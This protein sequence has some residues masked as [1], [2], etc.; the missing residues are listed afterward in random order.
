[1]VIRSVICGQHVKINVDI[2]KKKNWV[3][4]EETCQH[5]INET[6]IEQ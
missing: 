2:K 3:S 1:M 6:I 4:N 5:L